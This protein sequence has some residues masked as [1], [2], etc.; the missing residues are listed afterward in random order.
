MLSEITSWILPVTVTSIFA[1]GF[2][3]KVKVFDN[4][5]VGALKGLRT[6]YEILPSIVCLVVAVTMLTESG[7]M[8]LIGNAMKPVADL[9]GVPSEV[10]PLALMSSVSGGG[11][12]TV[13]ESILKSHGPDSFIGRVASVIAGSTETTFYAITVYYSAVAVRNTRHTLYVGLFADFIGLVLSSFFVRI[14]Q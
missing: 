10:T 5:R 13:F 14:C 9:F 11:S 7:A 8:E 2:F 4:F 1:F 6:V 3:K 12:I